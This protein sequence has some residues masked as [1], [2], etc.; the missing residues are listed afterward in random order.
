[1]SLRGGESFDVV[2]VG[3]TPAGITAAV[4]AAREGKTAALLERTD[5]VGGLPANGLGATDIFTRGATGGLFD[6]FVDRIH[7]HYVDTY[8]HD[9]SQVAACDDGYH[10]EP[11]VAEAVFEELLAE[12]GITVGYGRQFDPN[13]RNVVVENG[14][15]QSVAVEDRSEGERQWIEGEVFVDATY[16]GD[17]AASAGAPYRIGREGRDEFDEPFAGKVYKRCG[18]PVGP[19]STGEG[20]NAIQAYNYRLCLTRDPDNRVPISKPQNYDRGEYASLIDDIE[21]DDHTDADPDYVLQGMDWITLRT[22]LPN[23]KTDANNHGR[24]YVSTDLPE[25][26]W[27]WPTSG[28]AWRDRFAERLREYTLGLLWFAQNDPEL[29]ASFKSAV[30]EWGLAA[31]EYE[32]NDNFPR[33]VYVREGRRVEGEHVFTAHDARPTSEDGRPPLY[34]TSVTASHYPIDSHAV[35]KREPGRVNL[36][37]FL[38][39]VRS[40]PYTV[41]YEVIVPREVDGLLTPVA[42]SG[43]HLGFSTIRMEPCWMALGEAAG[44]AAA[45]ALDRERPVRSV[46]RADLQ[47][48][49]IAAG[50][51]LVY[52]EDLSPGDRYYDAAQ[53]LG[54]RGFLPEWDARL[55]D[56]IDEESVENWYEW[57]GLRDR[58]A[59]DW[60]TT[61]RGEYLQRVFDRV[62]EFPADRLAD[63][64]GPGTRPPNPNGYSGP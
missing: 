35:R 17:L 62:R 23:G 20:D 3:G 38:S 47:L 7:D 9:S 61:T 4:A 25:E 13:P 55:E 51:V 60:G 15:L 57:A 63:V 8:G 26:N 22:E 43:T 58:P 50:A 16:E 24:S 41:P 64:R 19:G 27:P 18:G 11:S 32:D 46:S 28:W 14:T 6:E 36:E 31:D 49:L 21:S 30:S 48:E 42:V 10:F 39:D 45:I 56:P 59:Y 12:D 54:V 40:E 52:F 5:H 37:G 53:F 1:M 33:Q 29:P 34:P 2:V 44:T